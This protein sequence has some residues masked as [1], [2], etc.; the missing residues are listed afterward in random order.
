MRRPT[1][2]E[3]QSFFWL[4]EA[5]ADDV[6]KL[7]KIYV[8]IILK[9]IKIID[10][11]FSGRHIPLVVFGLPVFFFQVGLYFVIFTKVFDVGLRILI[12]YRGIRKKTVTPGAFL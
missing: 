5:S 1:A 6:C 9:R 3:S 7:I 11:D 4:L 8:D 10:G 12:I 2:I